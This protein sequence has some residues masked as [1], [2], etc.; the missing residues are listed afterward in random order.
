[1][2]LLLVF[3]IAILA[4]LRKRLLAGRP[5]DRAGTWDCGYAMPSARMQYTSSSYAKPL[6]HLFDGILQTRTSYDAP[7]D[8]FP[9][10]AGLHTHT[11]DVFRWRIY[12]PLFHAVDRFRSSLRWMQEGRVQVYI[13]YIA[14]T[15]VVLLIGGL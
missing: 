4:M 3:G 14:V 8:L 13:L 9:A 6:I 1:M 15:L 7:V 2:A 10:R 11:E 12:E 5:V